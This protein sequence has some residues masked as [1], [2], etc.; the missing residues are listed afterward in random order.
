VLVATKFGLTFDEY[1]GNMTGRDASP[2]YIK[3][4]CEASLRRLA[5]DHIDLYQFHIGGYDAAAVGP[6]LDARDEL[7][8]E[9][10]VRYYAWGAEPEG[11]RRLSSEGTA[12]RCSSA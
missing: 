5:T 4:A 8:D 11:A 1:S 6:V 7:A 9:G 10:K 12:L 3:Q 2:A